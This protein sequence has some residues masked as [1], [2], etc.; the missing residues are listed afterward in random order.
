MKYRGAVAFLLHPAILFSQYDPNRPL[1]TEVV[2]LGHIRSTMAQRFKK[3]PNYTCSMNIERSRRPNP[4]KGY[5]FLDTVRLEVAVV[6][7]KEMFAWPG[8]S[9]FQTNDLLSLVQ[10]EGAIGTGDF[11]QHA[12]SVFL[13]P[14]TF[15]YGGQELM[16]NR[17]A[18]RFDFNVPRQR[19]GY[20]LRIGG[21]LQGIV[22]YEGSVWNDAETYDLIRLDLNIT[23]IPDHLPVRSGYSSIQYA[24]VK[25]PEGEFW[26]P[27]RSEMGLTGSDGTESRNRTVFS[28]CREFGTQSRLI[29]EDPP[30]D[31][32]PAL[33]APSIRIDL[34]AQLNLQMKTITPL[35]SR[36][37]AI[38]DEIQLEITREVKR[39][40]NLIL[41]KRALVTGRI[42]RFTREERPIP[43]FVLHIA[44]DQVSFGNTT[45][46]LVAE[47]IDPTN[48]G[49]GAA[50]GGQSLSSRDWSRAVTAVRGVESPPPGTGVLFIKGFAFSIGSGLPMTWRTLKSTG[51]TPK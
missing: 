12:R 35:S 32:T 24:K 31:E 15:T 29:F 34:P 41:P 42:T 37:L 17:P 50:G 11:V 18:H 4:T 3:F 39:Q 7:N 27:S 8:S 51:D 19:S 6:D 13:G 9:Q 26:L 14:T 46:P 43:F 5:K 1:P 16:A 49:F 38:G 28:N 22:G 20:T 30:A 33:P 45:A 40:G 44:L 2:T 47:L 23:E 48:W 36:N 10:G 25:L 21:V